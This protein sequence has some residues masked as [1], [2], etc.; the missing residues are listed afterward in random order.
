M[1]ERSRPA[2]RVAVAQI[3]ARR[4]YAIPTILHRAGMLDR[5]FTDLT[6]SAWWLT[7]IA[8]A[9]APEQLPD[10]LNRLLARRIDQVP[11]S[12]ITHFTR[13]AVSR[14][15]RRQRT[16]A[17]AELARQTLEANREFCRL[18]LRRG[19]GE[20][21][22]LYAFNGAAL[23]MLERAGKSGMLRIVEQT[24]APVATDEAL[25]GEERNRWPGWERGG[26]SQSDW[27]PLANREEAEWQRADVILCGS[28]YVVDQMR[29]R[30]VPAERT[31]VVPYGI[32]AAGR[33]PKPRERH[34]RPLRL[35]AA[36]NISLRKGFQ[37][38]IDAANSL[39]SRK[40]VIRIVGES[41]VD[42]AAIRQLKQSLQVVGAVS[43]DEMHAQYNWADALV[44]PTL[45]EGSANVVYEALVH[46]LPVITTP[47]A[48]SVV[49]DGIEGWI[50]PIRSSEAIVD[51]VQKL[52]QDRGL[53]EQMS[54][55]ALARSKE[56]TWDQYAIRLVAAIQNAWDRH[57][58]ER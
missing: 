52:D 41:L 29:L 21:N 12:R 55:A 37:Y 53:L 31:I 45:S 48:G 9:A 15:A 58:I 42:E 8:A 35:L 49:R 20:S 2:P 40:V 38:L 50:V 34:D 18:V 26:M 11:S 1:N 33:A 47:H 14:I 46:G 7:A 30:N 4:H 6:A 22:A 19:F 39:R 27:L 36:G 51:A 10:G 24:S 56:F 32:D 13:F 3:G 43:R 17:P 57:Q 16:S 44:L 25:L 54:I 28:Q 23:E 5:F